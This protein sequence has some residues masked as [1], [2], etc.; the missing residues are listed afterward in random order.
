MLEVY[1]DLFPRLYELPQQQSAEDESPPPKLTPCIVMPEGETIYDF[2]WYPGMT[3]SDPD[4]CAILSTARDHPI[5]LYDAFDGHIRATYRLVCTFFV[6]P[7]T[8]VVPITIYYILFC[9]VELTLTVIKQIHS[10]R[11]LPEYCLICD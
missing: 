2:C 11:K 7:I 1:Y 6:V 9:L 8:K 5:H 4:T 10:P 3:S